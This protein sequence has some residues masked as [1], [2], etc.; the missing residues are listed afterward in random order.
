M[1]LLRISASNIQHAQNNSTSFKVCK[2]IQQ[3][4]FDNYGNKVETDIIPLVQYD[5]ACRNDYY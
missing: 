1:H 3:I 5:M 4:T 2:L